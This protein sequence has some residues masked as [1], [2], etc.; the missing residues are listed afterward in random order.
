[1]DTFSQSLTTKISNLQRRLESFLE[2]DETI[3][4]Q[5]DPGTK[6][7]FE[8]T[9]DLIHIRGLSQGLPEDHIDRTIV[10]FNRLATFFDAGILLENSDGR[11]RSQ[12]Y[13]ESGKSFLLKKQQQVTLQLPAVKLISALRTKPQL[14]LKKLNLKHLDPDWQTTCLL[15]KV[16]PD[17]AFILLSRMP[18]L[19]LKDHINHI[20]R[21]LVNGFTE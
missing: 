15:I 8:V 16:T 3:K 2:N 13:F 9:R 7:S 5:E 14:I 18:D 19:W 4:H 20:S 1:M 12:A 21:E 17:F 11:W 6:F 10:I